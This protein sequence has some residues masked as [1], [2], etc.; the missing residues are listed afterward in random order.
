MSRYPHRSK[1]QADKP[2]RVQSPRDIAERMRRAEIAMRADDLLKRA[3]LN[4]VSKFV[5]NPISELFRPLRPTFRESWR[6]QPQ[7]RAPVVVTLTKTE[8]KRDEA[9]VPV[10]DVCGR[11]SER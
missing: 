3:G 10:M 8:P 11:W 7:P 6:P 5:G 1:P 4:P 2:A 9:D